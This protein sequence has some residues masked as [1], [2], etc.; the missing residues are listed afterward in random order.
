MRKLFLSVAALT[1]ILSVNAATTWKLGETDFAVD[2]IFHATTGPGVVTTGLTLSSPE[3]TTNIFYSQIDLT[4]PTLELRGVEAKET[5]DDRETVLD[6]GNRHNTLGNGTYVAGINGDFFNMQGTP[7]RTCGHAMADGYFYNFGVSNHE[8]LTYVTVAD[9]KNVRILQNVGATYTLAFADGTTYPVRIDPAGEY[10][11]RG[12]DCLCVYSPAKGASTTTNQWGTERTA[13]IVSG[14]IATRDA[15]YEITGEAEVG[16]GDMAIPADGVV[17]SGH[18][19]AA[20]LVENLN[21]GDRVSTGDI[22]ITYGKE[23][24]NLTQMIGGCSMLV[25]GGNV[26]DD[27]YFSESIIDHFVTPQARSAVGYNEDRT[28]L[29]ILVADKYTENSSKDP[30]KMAY[31]PSAGLILKDVAYIMQQLGCYTAMNFDGGGSSQLYNNNIGIRNIPY[32]EKDPHRAVANGFFAVS[33]TPA[34]NEIAAIEVVQKNVELE[35]GDEFTP[36]VYGFNKYGVLVDNDVKDFTITVDSKLGDVEGSKFITGGLLPGET[37]AVVAKGDI[38]CAVRLI[39]NGGGKYVTSGGDDLPVMLASNYEPDEPLGLDAKRLTLKEQWRFLNEGYTDWDAT[40][41]NWDSEDSIKAKSCNRFAVGK[42]GRLYT[43]DM[44]TMSIA[45]IDEKG[46][47]TPL[48]KLPS[49]AGVTVEDIP[50]YYGTAIS[51]DDAGN[52]IIGHLFTKAQSC[53]VYT[54]Y[55]PAQNKAKRLVIDLPEG[56]TP[57]RIDVLG[58]VVGNLTKNAYAFVNHKAS[59]DGNIAKGLI[60][61]FTGTDDGN[62]DNVTVEATLTPTL[63]GAGGGNTV[64]FMQPRYTTVEE[65]EANGPLN[66]FFWYSKAG[67]INNWTT[68]LFCFNNGAYSTNYSLNWNNWAASNGFDTFV[69]DGKRFF[70]V[71]YIDEDGYAT[72]SQ[73]MNIIVKDEEGN[74]VAQWEN[75]DYS[76]TLGYSTITAIPMGDNDVNIYVYNSTL[77]V[78]GKDQP[79]F[80][81]ALLR[82]SFDEIVDEPVTDITPAGLDFD[83]YAE[84]DLFKLTSTETQGAWSG[85]AGFYHTTHPTAFDE[86]GHLTSY[87]ERGGTTTAENVEKNVQPGFVIRKINEESGNVLAITQPWSPGAS[88]FAWPA[89]SWGVSES[90]LSFYLRNEDIQ[91]K[92][93]QRHYIRVRMVYNVTLRGCHYA[94]DVKDGKDLGMVRSIYATHENNYVVPESDHLIGAQ[95]A[96]TGIDFAQWVDETGKVEDIPA[97]PV[98]R[99][100]ADDEIEAWDAAHGEAAKDPNGKPAY[101]INSDRFRV[102]EFDTYVDNPSKFTISA[103]MNLKNRNASYFIKEVKFFDLGT[104]EAKATLLGRRSLGWTYYKS[105]Y[106][107]INNVAVDENAD[108][109][110]VYYNLQGIQVKN[111]ANGIYIVRRGNK[112]TKEYIR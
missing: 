57:D 104:D 78:N 18:G 30:D 76:S 5:G 46:V 90:Q 100:P 68:D 63:Y 95:Y 60:L 16:V 39:I 53:Q 21:I 12:S 77:K 44:Q 26:A 86:D 28:Q 14:S 66:S 20:T 56:Y 35:E 110:P 13:K 40:A 94:L 4:N 41:P 52:F 85:P 25:K 93:E 96:S 83:K 43:L 105:E 6:M 47:M 98:V 75:P 9:K 34:D 38:K 71:N 107:G 45:E 91:N 55:S 49:L 42:N 111:P 24:L 87:L 31:G 70:V 80:A 11:G 92:P 37:K 101:I 22:Q 89:G 88:R 79:A 81:G 69:L 51:R 10:G 1:A 2:T 112:T 7:T 50:D 8:W 17:L 84:G 65:V 108:A 19:I 48:Y 61:H 3:N 62:I 32:G 54:I 59:G 64:H 73:T 23:H 99:V 72:N 58:R 36:R 33:N 74:T 102:Y 29:T 97:T 82:L 109:E 106:T 67:T 15:V 103:Q 27:K